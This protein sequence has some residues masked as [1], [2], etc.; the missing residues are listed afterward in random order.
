VERAS[1]A[2]FESMPAKRFFEASQEIINLTFFKN[3]PLVL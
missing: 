3:K 1:D 2:F